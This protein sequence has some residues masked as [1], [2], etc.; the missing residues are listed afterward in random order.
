MINRVII[1]GFLAHP[2]V[3]QFGND[4][5]RESYFYLHNARAEGNDQYVIQCMTRADKPLAFLNSGN[6]MRGD[7]LIVEGKLL[8]RQLNNP[9][10]HRAQCVEARIIWPISRFL[11][12]NEPRADRMERIIGELERLEIREGEHDE[13]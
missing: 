5:R 8:S 12:V 2:P 7:M 4:G 13:F 9:A 11:M 10:P 6:V 3:Q 1:S